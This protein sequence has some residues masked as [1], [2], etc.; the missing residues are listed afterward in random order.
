LGYGHNLIIQLLRV[1]WS[2][3]FLFLLVKK[4]YCL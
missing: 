2:P 1:L 4:G 3:Q